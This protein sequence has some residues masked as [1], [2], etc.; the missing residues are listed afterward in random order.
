MT[1]ITRDY[2]VAQLAW[3]EPPSCAMRSNIFFWVCVNKAGR[4]G[5]RLFLLPPPGQ[6]EDEEAWEGSLRLKNPSSFLVCFPDDLS[7]LRL[8]FLWDDNRPVATI[9]LLRKGENGD[10]QRRLSFLFG[11]QSSTIEIT[12]YYAGDRHTFIQIVDPEK[13]LTLE[14][15][16]FPKLSRLIISSNA[17]FTWWSLKL[18]FAQEEES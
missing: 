2:F 1:D 18:E 16:D 15:D 17:G 14:P 3:D 13:D 10:W 4:K 6:G 9:T 11:S 5:K 12:S 7:D 8:E